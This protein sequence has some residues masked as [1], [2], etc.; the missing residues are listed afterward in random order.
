M[1][2]TI[3]ENEKKSYQ[4]KND[5]MRLQLQEYEEQFEMGKRMLEEQEAELEDL[6]QQLKNGGGGAANAE[7]P[8][9]I[10][11]YKNEIRQKDKEIDTVHGEMEMLQSATQRPSCQRCARGS[12]CQ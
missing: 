5:E 11:T 9:M 2:K 6:R 3:M 10:E 4:R 7:D 8:R 1:D 12:T